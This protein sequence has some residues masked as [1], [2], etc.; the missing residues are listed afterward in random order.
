VS[1]DLAAFLAALSLSDL[2][3]V[4]AGPLVGAESA[5]D[6]EHLTEEELKGV[7]VPLIKAKKLMQ[8]VAAK[9]LVPLWSMLPLLFLITNAK[10]R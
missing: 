8:A 4:L 6:L 3:P 1:A 7:G 2:G 10:N 9:V 5:S